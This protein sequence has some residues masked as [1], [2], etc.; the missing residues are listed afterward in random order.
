MRLKIV[1]NNIKKY[2]GLNI[3]I[4]IATICCNAC[5]IMSFE[6]TDFGIHVAQS[7][8]KRNYLDYDIVVKSTTG[9]SLR[10]TKGDNDELEPFY[11][12]KTSFYNVTLLASTTNN[13]DTVNVFEGTNESISNVYNQISIKHNETII[14]NQLAT[15]L[16]VSIGEYINLHIQNNLYQYK[17]ISIVD[18]NEFTSSKAMFISGSN[19]SQSFAFKNMYNLIM[20]DVKDENMHQVSQHISN[21]YSKYNVIDTNDLEY[22]K[23]SFYVNLNFVTIIAAVLF[24]AIMLVLLSIYMMRLK[25]QKNY[26]DVNLS[27]KYFH[28]NMIIQYAIY[29]LISMIVSSILTS[30]VCNWYLKSIDAYELYDIRYL[31]IILSSTIIFIAFMFN[32]L[33]KKNMFKLQPKYNTIIKLS[34]LILVLVSLLFIQNTDIYKLLIIIAA[35]LILIIMVDL[36]MWIKKYVPNFLLKVYIFDINKKSSI[37]KVIL[38]VHVLTMIV[39]SI[40]ICAYVNYDKQIDELSELIKIDDVVVTNTSNSLSKQYDQIRIDSEVLIKDKSLDLVC[41][42]NGEQ[43]LKYTNID[44]NEYEL[45]LY[46]SSDNYVILPKFYSSVCNY[47]VGEEIELVNGKKEKYTI[48]KIVDQVYSTFAIVN[49]SDNLKYGYVIDGKIDLLVADKF[50]DYVYS[51]VNIGNNIESMSDVYAQTFKFL[52]SIIIGLIILIAWFG[53]YLAYMEFYYQKPNIDKLEKLG[54]SNKT[55]INLEICKLII[56]VIVT[57]IL[58]GIVGYI[59]LSYFDVIGDLFKTLIFINADIKVLGIALVISIAC[60]ILGFILT[61][62]LINKKRT[63]RD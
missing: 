3:L 12:K 46:N 50:S 26:F 44:L 30:I 43:L 42:F 60:Q 58:G 38:F 41:G 27:T 62:Y 22:I 15:S 34:C 23:S 45:S 20:L 39:L 35:V 56:N 57:L 8:I 54:M 13:A 24:M 1:Y 10:G 5:L 47:Q 37:A 51:V 21:Y 28:L 2:L 16:G 11:N 40:A 36:I 7:R 17:V 25:K 53:C 18:S 55:I 61:I 19:I 6:V 33:P 63:I 59:I 49:H 31:S 14:T 4:L 9:L 48:L 32:L 29:T 52:S